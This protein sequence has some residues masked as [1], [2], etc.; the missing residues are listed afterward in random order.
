MEEETIFDKILAGNAP[1]D[2]VYEDDHVM[3]FRDI[4]PQAPVHVIVIPRKKIKSF[5]DL[6]DYD[7]KDSGRFFRAVSLVASALGLDQDG[8]RIVL[9]CGKNGQQTVDYLHAHILG[10]RQMSWPPG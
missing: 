1:A 3:A 2:I 5:K 8:Y 7:V 9:N 4:N 6:K 10:E